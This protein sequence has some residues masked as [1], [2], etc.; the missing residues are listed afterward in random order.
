MTIRLTTSILIIILACSSCTTDDVLVSNTT[1]MTQPS[2]GA[3]SHATIGVDIHGGE[4]PYII[5]II[6]GQSRQTIF[7]TK[8]SDNHNEIVMDDN[9]AMEYEIVIKSSDLQESTSTLHLFPQGVSN[10]KG[11]IQIQA[12]VDASPVYGVD[13]YLYEVL[14]DGEHSLL[15]HNITDPNGVFGHHDLPNGMYVL[16]VDMPEKYNE[17][18]L[19]AYSEGNR[20]EYEITHRKVLIPLACETDLDLTLLFTR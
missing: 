5:Q 17:F 16:E 2:C 12:L 7:S 3:E 4:S 8:T 9:W 11:L 13:T 18:R 14:P 6:D 10:L 15:E 20:H 19:Q 1:V